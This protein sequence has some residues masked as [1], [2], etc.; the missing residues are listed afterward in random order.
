MTKEKNQASFIS[1]SEAIELA[2]ATTG[3]CLV[4]DED[5]GPFQR[6]IFDDALR[7]LTGRAD[8]D[9]RRQP[10]AAAL[11]LGALVAAPNV[12]QSTALKSVAGKL[13]AIVRDAYAA[14]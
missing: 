9:I 10:S 2:Q 13:R 8:L 1:N 5:R 7:A 4:Q 11:L 14:G 3:F 12:E 6:R